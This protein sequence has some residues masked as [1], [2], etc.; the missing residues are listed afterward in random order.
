MVLAGLIF[1]RLVQPQPGPVPAGDPLL[2]Q[3]PQLCHGH[4]AVG[5]MHRAPP[6]DGPVAAERWPRT[7]TLTMTMRTTLGTGRPPPAWHRRSCCSWRGRGVRFVLCGAVLRGCTFVEHSPQVSA[8]GLRCLSGVPFWRVGGLIGL[9]DK[10]CGQYSS[11]LW[12]HIVIQ[13]SIR[14]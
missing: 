11:S 14:S 1:P 7:T 10:G 2:S 13:V 5:G 3:R 4:A 8:S 6:H 9:L 12:Q